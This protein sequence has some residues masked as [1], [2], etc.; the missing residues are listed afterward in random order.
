MEQGGSHKADQASRGRDRPAARRRYAQPSVRCR[1]RRCRRRGGGGKEKEQKTGI[2]P[3]RYSTRFI[4]L[5]LA[6]LGK[7]YGGYEYSSS[8]T[9]PSIEEELWKALV[10]AC[11][12]SPPTPDTVDFSTCEYSK[13]GRTDRGVSAFGQVVA[14][15]VRSNRPPRKRKASS[16]LGRAGEDGAVPET[17][18][19]PRG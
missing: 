19:A 4:A 14:L 15:R 8:G 6:Y 11:L 1:R 12:I 16:A 9:L 3:S 18:E 7:N 2:D 13:C 5:K 17:A 10:K